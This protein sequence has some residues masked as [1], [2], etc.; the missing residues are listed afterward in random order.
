M[1][2]DAIRRTAAP[3][4]A[5]AVD[6][7]RRAIIAQ[8]FAPGARYA[9]AAQRNQKSVGVTGTC[10]VS[11]IPAHGSRAPGGQWD[12]GPRRPYS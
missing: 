3:L 5:E 2:V 1:T 8:E 7:L 6:A 12:R 11:W 9:R 10:R 4:R